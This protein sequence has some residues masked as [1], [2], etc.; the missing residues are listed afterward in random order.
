[1]INNRLSEWPEK[2]LCSYL[3]SHS[4]RAN[5]RTIDDVFVLHGLISHILNHG[6]TLYCAFIDCTQAF[7]YVVREQLWYKAIKVGFLSSPHH[8]FIIVFICDLF[9]SP[10]DPLM[11]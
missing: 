9:V 10:D 7:D 5:M 1:M 3:S 4:F 11:S 6:K 8:C 2:V